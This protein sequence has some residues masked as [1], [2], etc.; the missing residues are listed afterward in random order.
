MFAFRFYCFFSS[1]CLIRFYRLIDIKGIFNKFKFEN[2]G[3][4]LFF[5]FFLVSVSLGGRA[6]LRV[7][8]SVY[9]FSF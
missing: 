9:M 7:W 3:L 1:F 2:L 4:S 5:V 8:S 6:C